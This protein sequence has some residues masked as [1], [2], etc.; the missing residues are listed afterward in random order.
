MN[1]TDHADT[2]RKLVRFEIRYGISGD[3]NWG[4]YRGI[5]MLEPAAPREPVLNTAILRKTLG[6]VLK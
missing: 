2:K 5:G 1:S 6:V 4:R 3:C